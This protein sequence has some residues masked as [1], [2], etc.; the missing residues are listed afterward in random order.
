VMASRKDA[1]IE[2]EIPL[3]QKWAKQLTQIKDMGIQVPDQEIL[4]LLEVYNGNIE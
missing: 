2:N 4:H 1:R 3:A